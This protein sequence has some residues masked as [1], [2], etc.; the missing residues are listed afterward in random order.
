LDSQLGRNP[1]T[2]VRIS[3]GLPKAQ[4]EYIGSSPCVA[5]RGRWDSPGCPI[6]YSPLFSSKFV[7]A[8]GG[9]VMGKGLVS[10]NRGSTSKRA[11]PRGG[12]LVD[13]PLQIM[14][15]I[16]KSSGRQANLCRATS[17][18]SQNLTG[19][20][21]GNDSTPPKKSISTW[22]SG[23]LLDGRRGWRNGV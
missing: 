22:A 21:S 4:V 13:A 8:A 18:L 3:P 10:I 19:R 23:T 14:L 11:R 9:L 15:V 16:L 5:G 1:S 7:S 2:G 6:L 20:K 17:C 12:L